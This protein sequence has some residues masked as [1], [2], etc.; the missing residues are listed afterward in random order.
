[1]L[2]P[3]LQEAGL[4][5]ATGVS[6]FAFQ[7]TNAHAVLGCCLDPWP[8]AHSSIRSSLW[9]HQRFWY[10][11]PPHQMLHGCVAGAQS[12]SIA[13]QCQLRSSSLAYICDHQVRLDHL[14]IK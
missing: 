9:R 1:M 12:G 7:G 14:I 13:I 2:Q 8:A 3:L 11:P 10:A 6:A 4:L 5:A